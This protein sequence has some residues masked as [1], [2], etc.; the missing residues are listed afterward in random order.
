MFWVSKTVERHRVDGE[1]DVAGTGDALA[2]VVGGG[3]AQEVAPRGERERPSIAG[4]RL[5]DRGDAGDAVLLD[6]AKAE[7]VAFRDRLVQ[8]DLH[9]WVLLGDVDGDGAQVAADIH[10]HVAR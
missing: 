3:A 8:E 1:L 9:S 7:A 10:H 5:L 4:H 2:A 6:V